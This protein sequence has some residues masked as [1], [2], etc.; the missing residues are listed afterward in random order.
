M[1][2]LTT[3]EIA[4]S[5]GERTL[6]RIQQLCAGV[7][8]ADYESALVWYTRFFGREPD[9]TVADNESM[10]QVAAARWIYVVGDASRAG[11]ALLTLLT[12]DLAAHVA[13]LQ[14]RGLAVGALDSADS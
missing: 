5:N 8:V 9:I 11:K 10:W 12:D 6:V 4:E 1:E 13:E 2:A 14:G 7:A 3:C